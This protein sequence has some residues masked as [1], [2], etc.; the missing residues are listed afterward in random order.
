MSERQNNLGSPCSFQRLGVLKTVVF[1]EALVMYGNIGFIA[2]SN[3]KVKE[4]ILGKVVALISTQI[5]T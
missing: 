1:L 3:K 2:I 4:G 5:S